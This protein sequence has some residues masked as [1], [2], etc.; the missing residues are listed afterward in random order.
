VVRQHTD[1]I[2]ADLHILHQ[3]VR[4]MVEALIFWALALYG[5]TMVV[6]QS[7]GAMVMRKANGNNEEI[8]FVI[9]H[10][11]EDRIEGVLRT[12]ILRTLFGQQ[13]QRVVVIDVGSTD[14]TNVIVLK[15]AEKNRN[16]EYASVV[17]EH[18]ISTI[19][20][21]A[22]ISDLSIGHIHDLRTPN[23]QNAGNM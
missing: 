23:N 3:G 11:A 6:Y 4:A 2:L 7:V 16:I 14:E 19:L 18:D 9:T 13:K 21:S 17:D 10:N 1:A 15:M 12:L 20:E 5:A 22:C 8:H